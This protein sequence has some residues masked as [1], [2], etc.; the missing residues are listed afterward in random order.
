MD[1]SLERRLE[2]AIKAADRRGIK[3]IK[4]L[5][6]EAVTAEQKLRKATDAAYIAKDK[7]VRA[8]RVVILSEIEMRA[9]IAARMEK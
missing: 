4:K 3:E 8:R 5:E 1:N 6:R 7:L 2:K 9:K